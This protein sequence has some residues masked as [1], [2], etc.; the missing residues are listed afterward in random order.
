MITYCFDLDGTLCTNTEGEYEKAKPYINSIGA[1]NQLY[2]QGHTILIQTARGFTTGVDWRI[3]T[4][5]QLNE[6]GIKYHQLHFNKA[7]AHVYVDDKAINA[8][9]WQESAKD[10]LHLLKGY[11]S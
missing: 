3:L 4:E 6:W 10:P 1:L 9:I 7:S 5:K 2:E 8:Y 11:I